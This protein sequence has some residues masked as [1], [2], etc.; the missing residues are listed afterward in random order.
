MNQYPKSLLA[1]QFAALLSFTPCVGTVQTQF[2]LRMS[3]LNAETV[4]TGYYGNLAYL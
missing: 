1:K 2:L 3:K 4:S